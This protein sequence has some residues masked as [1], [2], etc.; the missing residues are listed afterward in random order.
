MADINITLSVT[1]AWWV[2]PYLQSVD[3]FCRLTG[4]EP[5]LNKVATVALRGFKVAI[6]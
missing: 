6:K 4:M 3:L 1:R 2:M 5:D